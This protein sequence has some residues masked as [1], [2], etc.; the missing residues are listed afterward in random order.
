MKNYRTHGGLTLIEILLYMG[1]FS[2]LMF[3]LFVSA[4]NIFQNIDRNQTKTMVQ[5]E[6]NFLM[7]KID[8]SLTGVTTVSTPPSGSSDNTLT[9]TNAGIP[10]I[11][12]LNGK[13]L[14]LKRGGSPT[15]TLNNSNVTVLAPIFSPFVIF[16]HTGTGSNPEYVTASFRLQTKTPSGQTYMQD[17]QTTKYVRK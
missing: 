9:V 14:Q 2:I 17:F 11:F 12:S 15:V 13:D 10:L 6:G 5:E 8:S 3:G 7:A 1:L 4:I 16:T